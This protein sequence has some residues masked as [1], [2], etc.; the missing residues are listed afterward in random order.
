MAEAS[1]EWPHGHV[2]VRSATRIGVDHGLSG[3]LVYRIHAGSE[4]GRTF[5]FVLKQESAQAVERALRF[6]RGLGSPATSSVPAC[7]GGLVVEASDTGVLLLEDVG[8]AQQGDVLVGCSDL[9]AL[10][11]VRALARVH[12]ATWEAPAT[13]PRWKA[14]ALASDEWDTRLCAAADR[15]PAVLTA[16]LAERLRGLTVKVEEAIKSLEAGQMCW[17]HGDAH[18]DNVLFRRDGTAVLLDWSGAMVGPPALDLARLLTEG[19]NAGDQVKLARDLVSAY[20]REL[21]R[22][23]TDTT[24]GD[25]WDAMSNG[26]ALLTQAAISWAARDETRP[27]Q[28]RMQALQ[29]NLLQSVCNWASSEQMLRAGRPGVSSVEHHEQR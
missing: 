10:A 6:H 13:L 16:S 20:A 4:L 23:R 3:G 17:I 24:I 15:F 11:A 8:P 14:R 2:R 22:S 28:K 27:P 26:L 25:L 1:P 9:Q 21:A 19:V 12:G 5:S 29:A 18:L 7:L